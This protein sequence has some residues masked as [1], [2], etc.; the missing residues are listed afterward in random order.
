MLP[1]AGESVTAQAIK[2]AGIQV[3][4][5]SNLHHLHGDHMLINIITITLVWSKIDAIPDAQPV[6]QNLN[7]PESQLPYW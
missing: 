2:L 7:G 4:V 3:E 5:I 1:D 6:N